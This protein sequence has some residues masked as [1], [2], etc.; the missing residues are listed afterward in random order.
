[1]Q[2]EW[3]DGWSE[4][5]IPP[6]PPPTT[7]LCGGYNNGLCTN[8]ETYMR[9]VCDIQLQVHGYKSLHYK[10][11]YW[12]ALDAIRMAIEVVTIL[13]TWCFKKSHIKLFFICF[14]HKLEWYEEV[15]IRIIALEKAFFFLRGHIWWFLYPFH[16]YGVSFQIHPLFYIMPCEGPCVYHWMIPMTASR[17]LIS[18]FSHLICWDAKRVDEIMCF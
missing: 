1:M 6:P 11:Y 16:R 18:T 10:E 9:T 5:N 2:D 13:R 4:T 7:S 12:I 14:L 17:K 3:T 8:Q 15:W